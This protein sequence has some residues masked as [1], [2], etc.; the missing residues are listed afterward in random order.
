MAKK[1]NSEKKENKIVKF[2]NSPFSI[3][4]VLIVL[5]IVLLAF[6]IYIVKSVNLYTISGYTEDFSFLNGSIYVGFDINH[7]DSSTIIYSGEEVV[8]SEFE[9]GYYIKDGDS[10]EK[11]AVMTSD[12]SEEGVKL[13]ELLETTDFSFTE[14]HKDAMYLSSSNIKNL[15]GLCFKVSGTTTSDEEVSYEIPLDVEKISR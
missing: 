2:I 12:G 14:V 11:I 9:I 5:V 6:N 15:K 4:S 8:L 3:I 10:Y 7:F 1:E 13:K